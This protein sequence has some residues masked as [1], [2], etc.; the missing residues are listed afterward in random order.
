MKVKFENTQGKFEF[1]DVSDLKEF[2]RSDSVT[3]F[4]MQQFGYLISNV[5]GGKYYKLSA[6]CTKGLNALIDLRNRGMESV[7]KELKAELT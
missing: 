5:C 6:Y 7:V 4:D 3:D 2:L 1:E